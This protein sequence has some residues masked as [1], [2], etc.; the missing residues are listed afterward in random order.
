MKVKTLK[1][2]ESKMSKEEIEQSNKEIREDLLFGKDGL[3]PYLEKK[4][5]NTELYVGRY[6]EDL[7]FT[8]IN[9]N[10]WLFSSYVL[11]NYDVRL[12]D[13]QKQR[14]LTKYFDKGDPNF[15][16]ADLVSTIYRTYMMGRMLHK[17]Y[18]HY[19]DDLDKTITLIKWMKRIVGDVEIFKL[20]KEHFNDWFVDYSGETD[21]E[22][23]RFIL[24]LQ[25]WEW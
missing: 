24:D 18:E 4:D 2:I 12:N 16:Y 8:K 25:K 10:E 5:D 15:D 19:L 22:Y 23:H 14:K 20:S 11:N 7:M 6:G 1:D 13:K 3:K 9:D 17:T 21:E